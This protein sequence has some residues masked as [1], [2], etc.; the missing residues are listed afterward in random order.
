MGRNGGREGRGRRGR[1]TEREKEGER[2]TR[3]VGEGRKGTS[4]QSVPPPPQ[5]KPPTTLNSEAQMAKLFR[6]LLLEIGQGGAEEIYKARRWRGRGG[7][8]PR[9]KEGGQQEEKQ[10]HR[11][12]SGGWE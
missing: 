1:K 5:A 4:Q 12:G 7:V 6:H 9:R 10:E 11:N 3:F 8:L 2:G